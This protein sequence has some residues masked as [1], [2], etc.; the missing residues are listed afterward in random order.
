MRKY[1]RPG[2]E[3]EVNMGRD[4]GQDRGKKAVKT[5]SRWRM[6]VIKMDSGCGQDGRRRRPR[7]VRSS[8]LKKGDRVRK[9]NCDSNCHLKEN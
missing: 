8:N 6:D 7:H 4:G 1:P 3:D 2:G 5:G 9:L